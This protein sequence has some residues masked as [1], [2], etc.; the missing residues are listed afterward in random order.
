MMLSKVSKVERAAGKEREAFD[1]AEAWERFSTAWP[2]DVV[3]YRRAAAEAEFAKL[4]DA[5]RNEAIRCAPLFAKAWRASGRGGLP[6][7]RSWIRE[8]GWDVFKRMPASKPEAERLTGGS[9]WKPKAERLPDGSWWLHPDSPQ[10]HA[11]RAQE[12]RELGRARPGVTRPSEWPPDERVLPAP[13]EYGVG[14]GPGVG[15]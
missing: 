1:A 4:T 3:D 7:A 2:F 13:I 9:W 15:T 12:R 8:K 6:S 14:G 11:W 10:L 5:E